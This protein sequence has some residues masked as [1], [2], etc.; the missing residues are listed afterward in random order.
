M[1]RGKYLLVA[2]VLIVVVV[3]AWVGLRFIPASLGYSVEAEFASL[4]ERDHEL[5]EWLKT[6]PGVVSHTVH[7]WRKDGEPKIL[8][9]GFIMVRDGWDRPP[10]PDLQGKCE[11]LGYAGRTGPFRDFRDQ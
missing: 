5:E 7:V 11:A 1:T 6:Q 10:F 8:R 2:T 3:A 9:I 4:P